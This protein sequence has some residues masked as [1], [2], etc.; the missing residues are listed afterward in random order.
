MADV[1]IPLSDC[2]IV[3]ASNADDEGPLAYQDD[4]EE[5]R[6][7]HQTQVDL[8]QVR[9][10]LGRDDPVAFYNSSTD[11]ESF[12]RKLVVAFND[13]EIT[14]ETVTP[15]RAVFDSLLALLHNRTLP[16]VGYY[17][18]WGNEWLTSAKVPDPR[19]DEKGGRY[20]ATVNFAQVAR[21]PWID[22]VEE[23]WQP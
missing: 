2:V 19:R 22:V 3:L 12:D 7:W 20:Y 23:P 16:Y 18:Q 10:I 15:D 8:G 9:P 1:T 5:G 13:A 4:G 6:V 14:A 17:D 11:S 21:V